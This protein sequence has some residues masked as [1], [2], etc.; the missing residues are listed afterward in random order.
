M[1]QIKNTE[2]K[3]KP[4]GQSLQVHEAPTIKKGEK[5]QEEMKTPK[6][7]SK[8]QRIGVNTA[9]RT[10][11]PGSTSGNSNPYSIH[12]M[13]KTNMSSKNLYPVDRVK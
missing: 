11:V 9:N 12:N 7:E 3:K 10:T 6:A 2:M 4:F 13:N 8:V 1:I 5:R